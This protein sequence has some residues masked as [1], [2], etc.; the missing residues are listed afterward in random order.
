MPASLRKAFGAVLRRLPKHQLRLLGNALQ[1]DGPVAAFAF[2]R[3]I[4][5]DST[6][7]LSGDL[8]GST[9]SMAE[10]F[11]ELSARLPSGLHPAERAMRIDTAYTLPDDY[12]QKVDVGSMAFSLEARDPLLDH[13]IFEWAARLP[14]KWK[15]R[16][17][18]EQVS[19]A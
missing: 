7:I 2:M 11:G 6:D 10:L 1:A 3:S 5:K 17:V 4:I 16:G 19:A 13:S 18:D 12:L 8:A 14:I 15:L 9:R